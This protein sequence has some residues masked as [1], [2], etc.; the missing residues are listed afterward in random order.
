MMLDSRFHRND[1]GNPQEVPRVRVKP[2]RRAWVKEWSRRSISLLVSFVMLLSVLAPLPGSQYTAA[3]GYIPG[4]IG[5]SGQKVEQRLFFPETGFSISG[6]NFEEYFQRRGGL[7]NFGY[8]VSQAFMLLG[9]KVQ[10]FQRLVI[11]I[12]P[13][14][15]VGLLNILDGDF[16]PYTSINGTIIPAVDAT[17][18]SSAPAPGI[19]GSGQ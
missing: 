10:I 8:P 15:S 1:E 9:T 12:R 4:G 3:A 11:Q 19:A 5:Q 18:V 2:S 7:R 14:G 17:L 16:M 6:P 13:D